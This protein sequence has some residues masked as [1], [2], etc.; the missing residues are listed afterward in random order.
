MIGQ[1]KI[2][3]V[4]YHYLARGTVAGYPK[5]K[6]TGC[7]IASFILQN[8]PNFLSFQLKI[9]DLPKKQTQ[10]KPNSNPIK[11]NLSRR[12]PDDFCRDE[13]GFWLIL[14]TELVTA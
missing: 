14:A 5:V 1:S 10:F 6:Y 12:S 11:P 4:I 8:K 7:P 3:L 2:V 13:D 9:E